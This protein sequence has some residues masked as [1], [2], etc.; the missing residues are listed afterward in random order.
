MKG[1][2]IPLAWGWSEHMKLGA[3]THG[4]RNMAAVPL[5]SGGI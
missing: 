1:E 2:A 3:D 4:L 5:A